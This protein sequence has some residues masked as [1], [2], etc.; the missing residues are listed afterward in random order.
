MKQIPFLIIFF[1]LFLA[2]SLLLFRHNKKELEVNQV[3]QCNYS[4]CKR[5]L[6][7]DYIDYQKRT[8]LP[9]KDAVIQVNIGLNNPFYTNVHETKLKNSLY[10]LVNKYNYLTKDYIPNDLVTINEYTKSNVK[11]NIDAY[12]DFKKMANDIEKEDMHIRIVSAYRSYNYQDNLYNNYLKYDSKEK[13]DTYSARA[14]YSEHQTGLAI[15]IDNT[16]V[17][18]NRFHI[19]QEFTWMQNNA[20]KY[21]FI[22]RYPLGKEHI[23]GYKYEPW[24]YRYV[25]KDIAKYIYNSGLTY[26]EYYYEFI[27]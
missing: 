10:I 18:Y 15:D 4:F 6:L 26:E 8:N 21:G 3:F 25:G 23:T 1:L 20:Y 5:E 22:L 17:D 19:T 11:M 12:N 7:N 2:F 14:G 24:H 13:V 27:D 9:F 16:L